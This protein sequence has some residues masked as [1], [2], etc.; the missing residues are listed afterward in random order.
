[1]KIL[2]LTSVY[3]E[4]D[5]NNEVVTPTVKY[6]AEKWKELENDVCV[7]HNNSCFPIF[8]Y[9]IPNNLRKKIASKIGFTLPTFSSRKKLARKE[10]G[11]DIFRLPM[12]KLIPHR[13]FFNWQIERQTDKIVEIIE[14]KNFKPDIIVGHWI[15]PQIDLLINLSKIYKT[16]TS[17]VFHNDCSL[18]NIRQFNLVEKI[19]KLDAIGC[20]NKSDAILVKE[21]LG[22]KKLPFVC[23]SG[24][25]DEQIK[26]QKDFFKENINLI[27]KKSFLYVGRL[28]KYKNVDTIL[29]ALSQAYPKKDFLLNIVGTGAEKENLMKLSEELGIENNV[30]F[31]GQLNREDVFNMMRDTYCFTMVS[32][33]ETF[34]MVYIEAMLAGCITIA[35]KLG[36][37][38][39]VI[40][41]GINGFLS[42][43]ADVDEL[44]NIY[45][46]LEQMKEDEIEKIRNNAMKTAF[47]FSDSMVS[48]KYLEDILNW[49]DNIEN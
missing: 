48:K 5:D 7:I 28:V 11:I 36:G 12:F 33:N 24:V 45:K 41:T 29:K 21:R 1:M 17:L 40:S 10:K 35:S 2:I 38:D 23:Y 34:G 13:K 31:H 27:K 44:T 16:K 3:P 42:K 15:N 19:I 6:F 39:G 46:N 9:F 26:K 37:V 22:L 43:Q 25:P 47:G 20:R 49:K 14:E 32:D 8:F 18:K 4:P 30:I